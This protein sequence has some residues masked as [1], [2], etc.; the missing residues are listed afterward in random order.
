MNQDSYQKP[1]NV[2]VNQLG[3]T[4]A[5]WERLMMILATHLVK[6]RSIGM[7]SLIWLPDVHINIPR[8]TQKGTY[9]VDTTRC[10]ALG[11]G[12]ISHHLAVV[13]WGTEKESDARVCLGGSP[14]PQLAR[15]LVPQRN[16]NEPFGQIYRSRFVRYLVARINAKYMYVSWESEC[17]FVR[18][19]YS[20][21]ARHLGIQGKKSWIRTGVRS[22]LAT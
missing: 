17:P 1:A 18:R 5:F 12:L 9:F 3:F 15:G 22:P 7:E 20:T 13:G 11:R 4:E 19:T 14:K 6:L 21:L 2:S 16:Q 10:T 8:M